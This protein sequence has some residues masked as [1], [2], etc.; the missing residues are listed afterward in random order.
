VPELPSF[1]APLGY[2]A[3]FGFNETLAQAIDARPDYHSASVTDARTVLSHV[4]TDYWFRCASERFAAAAV[5]AGARAYVYRY[6]HLYSNASIFPTFGLPPICAQVVCHA[7]ELPFSFH[8]T[9]DFT[10]FTPA[11]DALSAAMVHYWAAFARGGDPN[12][13]G[14]SPTAWPA[15]DP[16]GRAVLLLN[17][18]ATVESSADVCGW[19]D[20]VA[21]GYLF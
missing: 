18:T 21:Q 8:R 13:A 2:L 20:S 4:V 5:A 14:G 6:A 12:S 9:P 19:W 1:L 11:E 17:T 10:S 15:W 7:S 3:V 16:A